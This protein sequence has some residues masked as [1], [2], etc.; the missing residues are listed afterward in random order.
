[1]NVQPLLS[2]FFPIERF[3]EALDLAFSGEVLKVQIQPR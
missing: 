1:V 3:A 2:H